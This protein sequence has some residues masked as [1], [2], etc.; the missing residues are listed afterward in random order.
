MQS[1]DTFRYDS[2]I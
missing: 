1:E 2:F